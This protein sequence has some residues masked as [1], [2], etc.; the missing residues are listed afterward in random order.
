MNNVLELKGNRFIQAPRTGS[1]SGPAMNGKKIVTSYHLKKLQEQIEQI[2]KFWQN[3]KKIFDGV[4][5]SVYY[6]KIVAKSNRISSLLKGEDSNAAIVGAKFNAEKNRH[7]IT[8]FLA[9]SDLEKSIERLSKASDILH[10]Q[11]SGEISKI[12]FDNKSIMAKEKFY[13]L[14]LSMSLF[15]GII[16]DASYIDSFEI[17]SASPEL[18]QSIIT[19]YDVKKDVKALFHELG[20]NLLSTRILD[21]QTVFLDENQIEL[22]YEKAPYLV[23][24]ATVDLAKLSPDDFISEYKNNTVV[25][26]TPASEPVVGVIDTLFDEHVYFNEWVDY[27]EMVS[28]DIPKTSDDYRHGTAV[29]SIIVDGPRLNPWLDDGCGRFRVRHFGVAVGAE[30]SSF[31][32]IKQIKS[33]VLENLDIKVWNISLGSNQEIN[34]NFISAEAAALDQIQFE[35]DVIF[36]IAG[37]N[38][39]SAEIVKI[40]SPADSVNSMVVNAVT[41]KG[42][43]T[44][45]SRRGLVLSFF[46]KPDVSYYGGSEEQYI[47]VCE[48]LGEANVAGTSYAAPWIA[49]KLSYLINVLGLNREVAKAMLIDAARGWSEKPSPETISLYGHGIVPIKIN[50]IVQTPEDEIKF[51]VSDISEKWNTYNYFFPVPMKNDKYP[52]IA[53]ATMCYF[54]MCDRTQGV[55]YTNTELNLHFGRLGPSDKVKDIQGDKQ[56]LDDVLDGEQFY[57]LEGD[58]RKLFRKWDN[59]KYIA[60]RATKKL[61][62]K[63]SYENKNWGM[64]VKTNNRLNP[65]DGVG[66]RFGVVV[67]LKEINGV[68]RIDEF[69]KS[70]TLNGWLVNSID[71]EHR[72]DIYQKFKEDIEFQ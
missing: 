56:N 38:K 4:L 68:N 39:V 72:I 36:V 16:A 54:P 29:S 42:L 41:K 61:V 25:L 59:V 10:Q 9:I 23:S 11:F 31:S 24:M 51:V 27:H 26:P 55:D 64:E 12:T 6:N 34:D 40:G 65:K 19:L 20:I 30:F 33:I 66:V 3:E 7:I 32:I 43:S 21:N 50:D 49:R 58:A 62:A 35:N 18:K 69:I 67:T 60:E 46:A 45:Y 22:L 70:C 48:P 52:Y 15:K 13:K 28:D 17:E 2:K 63:K 53:R 44:Q 5:I 1:P 47:N 57:L 14:S 37:T 8:Y 71:I